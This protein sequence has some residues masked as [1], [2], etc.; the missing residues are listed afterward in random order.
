MPFNKKNVIIILIDALRYDRL[1]YGGYEYNLTPNLNKI[2]KDSFFFKNHFANG[3]PT[4]VSFPSIFTST[5][6]LDHGGYNLGIKDRPKT[7]SEIFYKNG[8]DTFGVTSAHPSGNHFYYNR[9][10]RI[11]ENLLDFYQWFRQTLA[12]HLREDLT[13][14]SNKEI[15]KE[16]MLSILS[17]HYLKMLNSTIEYIEQFEKLGL[18]GKN[19]NIKKNKKKIYKEIKILKINPEIILQKFITYDY[20]YYLFFGEDKISKSKTFFIKLKENLRTRINNIINFFPRRKIYPAH[21]IFDRY[22]KYYDNN[23]SKS[24]IAFIHLFD[25]HEAKNFIFKFSFSYLFNL[26]K[27]I[28]LRNFKFGGLIYDLSVLMVDKELGNFFEYLKKNNILNN[29]NIIITS[30]HGL[31]AGFPNRP[32]T[33]LR[34]DLSQKFYDEFIHVPLIFYPKFKSNVDINNITSHI[35]FAPTL[36]DLC[37]IEKEKSFKGNSIFDDNYKSE[38][39]ISENTGTGICDVKNKNIYIC[40]RDKKLKITYEIINQN[41]KERD[42]YDIVNDPLEMKNLVST[43]INSIKRDYYL[44]QAKKRVIEIQNYV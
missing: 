17:S 10:F 25:V 26:I 14:F 29:S 32:K 5:F 35:D 11:Y 27:L 38:Y 20:L 28:F 3:C 24:H 30:D 23:K 1:F 4:S 15:T 16:D 19:F 34:T 36:L 13:K 7:F 22:K 42:V 21:E 43:K 39:V 18:L 12:V 9:G 31:T 41:V 37:S 33:E 44:N 8:Y 2:I 40:L 6:P